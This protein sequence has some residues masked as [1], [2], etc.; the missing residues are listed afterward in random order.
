MA[1]PPRA[2]ELVLDAF[3]ALLV[4]EGERAATLEAVARAAGVS[5]GGLLYHFASKEDLETALIERLEHHADEDLARM[6]AAPEGPVAYYL[7]T[8]AVEDSALDS[9][10]TAVAR[11]VQ[12]GRAEPAEALRRVRASWAD[13]LRPHV[14]DQ[15]ALDLVLLLGDGLYYNYALDRAGGTAAGLAGP[16]PRGTALDSLIARVSEAVG[17]A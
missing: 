15:A 16:L 14:R 7:R 10:L 13:A 2:R 11:L 17:E 8:S 4:D 9:A 6:A 1:R 3:E 12:G 5:K